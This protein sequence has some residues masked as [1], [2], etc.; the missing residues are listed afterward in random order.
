MSLTIKLYDLQTNLIAD[1]SSLCL[2]RQ[3]TRLL[4]QARTFQIGALANNSEFTDIFAT[5]GYRNLE[6]G[7]RKLIVW[8]DGTVIF[9]GRVMQ[10]ER[11]GGDNRADVTVTAMD[12]FM[13]LGFDSEERAGRVVRGS[14]TQPTAGTPYGTYDGN[15]IQPLFASSVAAQ[16]GISGPDL[17]YQ[18]LTN[19]Q[20][21]GTESDASPGEGAL[22]IDLTTGTFDLDVPPAVD[23][24]CVDSMDWPVLIGDFVTQLISTG[25]CDIDLRPVDP[26][27]GLDPYVMAALSAVSS[28]G[29]DRHAT[30]HFDWW[31]GSKNAKQVRHIENFATVN[32]KL[33]DY[34]GPRISKTRWKGNITPGTSGTTIDPTASRTRYG[35]FMSIRVFDS[36]GTESSSRPLYLALWNAEQGYRIY[37]RD[38]LYITPQDGSGA[39]YT[40][41]AD[42]DAGD[43]VTINVDASLGL[44]TLAET[45]RVYGY[46]KTWSREDVASISE[47]LTS[48]DVSLS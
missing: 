20:N 19:S 18:V 8:E 14:T 10:V 42:F 46:T 2:T 7:D 44:G 26:S 1:I 4:N 40:P 35:T 47:L 41:P 37:P 39:L 5:D 30:V 23:L 22:P 12:P 25:V 36:V 31:T 11:L 28:F 17:I 32:N 3:M 13:E 38:L 24:S 9:H 16:D 48:A 34:L 21:T 45:Q 15:F 43:L 27:E 6:T 29:T 33:Y